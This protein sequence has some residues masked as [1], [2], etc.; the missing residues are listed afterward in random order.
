MNMNCF[1]LFAD[2]TTPGSVRELGLALARTAIQ[3]TGNPVNPFD[4]AP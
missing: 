3:R 1:P 4:D 2:E